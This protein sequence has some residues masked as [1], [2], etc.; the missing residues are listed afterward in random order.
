MARM[1]KAEREA[2]ARRDTRNAGRRERRASRN[3]ARQQIDRMVER[4]A[5]RQGFGRV[6]DGGTLN[7]RQYN[8]VMKALNQRKGFGDLMRTARRA[9]TPRIG[10]FTDD[11]SET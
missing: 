10:T 2:Q 9:D 1:T 3:Q 7:T 4:E 6:G 8:S 5:A 11:N